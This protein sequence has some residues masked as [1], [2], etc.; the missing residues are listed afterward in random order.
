MYAGIL[1]LALT[2]YAINRVF[3]LIDERIMAWH[4]GLTRHMA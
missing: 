3:L 4:K 2:G 1:V